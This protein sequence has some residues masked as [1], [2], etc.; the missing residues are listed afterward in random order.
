MENKNAHFELLS[1][2]QTFDLSLLS[3]LPEVEK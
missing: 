2:G 1:H 3:F